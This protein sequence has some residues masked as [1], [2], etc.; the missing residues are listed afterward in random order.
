MASRHP[1]FAVELV[2]AAI[3]FVVA[4]FVTVL[5]EYR[6]WRETL[7]LYRDTELM[8]TVEDSRNAPISS[9]SS[10]LPSDEDIPEV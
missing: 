9:F 8:R 6:R 3:M 4:V 10:T 7:Y 5:L 2:A 1:S